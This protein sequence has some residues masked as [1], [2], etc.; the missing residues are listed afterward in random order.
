MLSDNFLINFKVYL[1]SISAKVIVYRK[2]K[3]IDKEAFLPVLRVCS[4]VLY[5]LDDV[6]H[7]VDLYHSTLRDTVNE[8]ANLRTKEMPR[9]PMQTW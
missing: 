6:D 1:Q 2:Y 3:S 8:Y 4:L 5:S 7:L 9:I